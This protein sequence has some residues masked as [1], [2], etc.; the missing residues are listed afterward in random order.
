MANHLMPVMSLFCNK[1]T[2]SFKIT[3]RD[4]SP[5]RD[6]FYPESIIQHFFTQSQSAIAIFLPR[7]NTMLDGR[8]LKRMFS[9]HGTGP[10]R[11]LSS[12]HNE[13]IMRCHL[14]HPS[15]T[16]LKWIIQEHLV[17]ANGDRVDIQNPEDTGNPRRIP[18]DSGVTWRKLEEPFGSWKFSDDTGRIRRNL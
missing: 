7:V 8:L 5:C 18:E 12:G 6:I 11:H 10:P 2:L 9:P 3:F 14:I 15:S 1:G 4:C 17:R 13:G 16:L